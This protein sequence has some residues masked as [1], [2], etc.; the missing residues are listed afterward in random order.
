MPRKKPK[1]HQG[2]GSGWAL[3]AHIRRRPWTPVYGGHPFWYGGTLPARGNLCGAPQFLPGP[4]GPWKG[5]KFSMQQLPPRAWMFKANV[6]GPVSRLPLDGGGAPA[7]GGGGG[8]RG[9]PV[10]PPASL[11]FSLLSLLVFFVG[12]GLPDAPLF[13]FSGGYFSPTA[14]PYSAFSPVMY[15]PSSYASWSSGLPWISPVSQFPPARTWPRSFH[16]KCS[17]R[18][19]K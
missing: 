15:L 17:I 5:R 18:C 11:R 10:W 1:R 19:S 9:G 2:D 16:C 4:Q 3:C 13:P 12:R 14:E 8:R 7:G 6:P